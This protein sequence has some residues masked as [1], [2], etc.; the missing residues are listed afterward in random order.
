MT[1]SPPFHGDR[2]GTRFG[3]ELSAHTKGKW[4]V[5][6]CHPCGR[7][8]EKPFLPRSTNTVERGLTVMV[9]VLPPKVRFNICFLLFFGIFFLLK[10]PKPNKTKLKRKKKLTSGWDHSSMRYG[11]DANVHFQWVPWLIC[12]ALLE[13]FWVIWQLNRTVSNFFFISFWGK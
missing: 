6:A 10:E 5:S 12:Q 4:K 11:L 13:F 3:S 1:L 8:G 2:E 7:A 9:P